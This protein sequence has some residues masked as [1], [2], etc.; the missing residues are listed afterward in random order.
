M[1]YLLRGRLVLQGAVFVDLAVDVNEYSKSDKDVGDK[2]KLTWEIAKAGV[3]TG[4]IWNPLLITGIKAR[5]TGWIA[6]RAAL[7]GG[8]LV[9]A[10]APV[11]AGYLIG[12]TVGTAIANQV[13]G[14]EGARTAMGFYSGGLLPN[15]E[16]PDLTDYQYIFKPTA[17]GG[18]VSAYDVVETAATTSVTL[19]SKWWD[20][21]PLPGYMRRGSPYL[22]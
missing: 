5:S 10:V 19:A 12:A 7:G 14:E 11:A 21:I 16:A 1:V 13:W 3:T 22:M 4:M 2:A 8:A 18:P 17:P 15:T 20:Q 9:S 6:T